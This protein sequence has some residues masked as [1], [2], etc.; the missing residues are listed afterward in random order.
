MIIN[1]QNMKHIVY[2]IAELALISVKRV[3]R[4]EIERIYEFYELPVS[5]TYRE[6]M[7]LLEDFMIFY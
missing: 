2:V 6:V 7:R 3:R 5:S 4:M 1:R